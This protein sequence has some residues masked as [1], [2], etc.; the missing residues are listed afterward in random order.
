VKKKNYDENYI[1]ITSLFPGRAAISTQEAAE[2]LGVN[3]KTL[4]W[5][6]KRV[7]NPLPTIKVNNRIVI[8]IAPFAQ[9]LC[10]Y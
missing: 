7:N 6:I 4:R 9:W 3:I 2:I 1:L 8:P 10:G 5:A